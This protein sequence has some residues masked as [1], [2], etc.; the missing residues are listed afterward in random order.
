[1]FATLALA[2]VLT[3]AGMFWQRFLGVRERLEWDACMAGRVRGISTSGHRPGD[4]CASDYGF[5]WFHVSY[6]L[7]SSVW[8]FGFFRYTTDVMR[9][10]VLYSTRSAQDCFAAT[11]GM[12]VMNS[13]GS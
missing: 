8:M 6:E 3:F 12:A 13:N 9:R 11:V 10:G 5:G 7:S 2:A 1:M 4:R